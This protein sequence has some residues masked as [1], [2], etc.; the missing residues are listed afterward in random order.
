MTP[1]LQRSG[2]TSFE[3]WISPP[4]FLFYLI[5]LFLMKRHVWYCL[6]LVL[7]LG[8]LGVVFSFSVVRETVV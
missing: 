7:L 1:T 6:A 4:P 5:F 8:A 2:G 3:G